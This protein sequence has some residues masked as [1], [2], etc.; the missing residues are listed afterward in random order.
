MVRRRD[1]RAG[2]G[3][4]APLSPRARARCAGEEICAELDAAIA[5]VD[6]IFAAKA[7]PAGA[8]GANEA[9]R[10]RARAFCKLPDSFVF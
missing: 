9:L 4:C 8:A 10:T 7:A 3:G 1:T 6:D 5:L 2:V